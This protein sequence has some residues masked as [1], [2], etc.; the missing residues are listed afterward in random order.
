MSLTPSC[1][2]LVH[3]G[4]VFSYAIYLH[5]SYA[6]L[7]PNAGKWNSSNTFNLTLNLYALQQLCNFIF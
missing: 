1:L 3:G 7:K 5:E 2:L 6:L 4:Q